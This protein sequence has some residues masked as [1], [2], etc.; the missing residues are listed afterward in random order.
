MLNGNSM[1]GTLLV[2]GDRIMK[3]ASKVFLEA[4]IL[5]AERHESKQLNIHK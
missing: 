1:S 5:G 4:Y 2:T 3:K